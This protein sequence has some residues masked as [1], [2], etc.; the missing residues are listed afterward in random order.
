MRFLSPTILIVLTLLSSVACRAQSTSAARYLDHPIEW[1]RS[2]EAARIAQNILSNQAP[3]GG[4]P[5]NT[6]TATKPYQGDPAMLHSTFDNKA[7]TDELRYIARMYVAT[8][9]PRYRESFLKGLDLITK[10]QYPNGGWPQYYPPP[11]DGYARYITF[12]DGAMA[13]LM[14]F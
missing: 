1:F 4:W 6:D 10:A 2:D 3:D 5:K 12:N 8:Q 7:T 14:F 11:K 9:E 13:R